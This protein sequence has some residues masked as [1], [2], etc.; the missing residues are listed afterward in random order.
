[1]F[2]ILAEIWRQAVRNLEAHR[3]RSLLTLI[4]IGIG[5][6]SVTSVRVFTSSMERSIIGRFERLG[7]S[8]VYV[9]HFPWQFGGLDWER[10][11]RR[12]RISWLEY[13][14]V[15]KA[16]G[17]EVWAALRY[18]GS[19]QEIRYRNK[20]EYARII[21]ITEEFGQVFPLE[22]R[23]GRYFSKEELNSPALVGVVGSRLLKE[24]TGGEKFSNITV[25]YEGRPIKVIGVLRA[26]GT[27]GGDMDGALLMPFPLLHRIHGMQR[28]KGDRTL[29][30]RAKDPT[31]LP[32][33]LLEMRVRGVL[34]QVRRLSPHQ[35]DNFSINRQDA[36]LSQVRQVTGYVQVAGLFIAGFSLLVG[37][38]GIANIL[39]IAVRE[40]RSEIGIQ[41]AMGAPKRFILGLFLTEGLL[42]TFLGGVLGLILTGV[43]TLS[44]S[45]VAAKEGL[46]L[47][48][49]LE[50]LLW[51]LSI[52]ICTGLVAALAPAWRAANLHP[53]EA[54]R[55]AN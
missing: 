48:I 27:F 40:R 47:G 53:I 52:T 43:L 54:I 26:Q 55:T 31:L 11:L 9:H 29:L 39:Y 13:V 5:I 12:P 49:L 34:R 25:V 22:L 50:D 4:T 1:M 51:G 45:D 8:T 30:I 36:L 23:E 2:H 6:F 21:G 10:Y 38:I 15:R 41:R 14:A 20:K 42:L 33:N 19:Y 24:L 46:V 17:A 37:G 3:R 18:E 35:E 7:A 44:L 32:L 16:L 28:Y